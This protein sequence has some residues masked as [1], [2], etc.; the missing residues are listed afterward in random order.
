MVPGL[1]EG[2]VRVDGT[3]IRVK[4]VRSQAELLSH[5][6]PR[7]GMNGFSKVMVTIKIES[8]SHGTSVCAF[9]IAL[10]RLG[11]RKPFYTQEEFIGTAS[12]S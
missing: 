3:S 11:T 2:K 7:T 12:C 5:G 1:H 4:R 10:A 9:P 8:K 6:Q